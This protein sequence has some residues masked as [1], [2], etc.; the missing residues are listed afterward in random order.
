SSVMLK[1]SNHLCSLKF[2][3]RNVKISI[4]LMTI[5]LPNCHHSLLEIE[6][7]ADCVCHLFHLWQCTCVSDVIF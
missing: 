7:G 1:T 6:T 4:T 5:L 2:W 3:G